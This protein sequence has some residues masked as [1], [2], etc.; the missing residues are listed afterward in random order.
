MI[1]DNVDDKDR[2]VYLQASFPDSYEMLVTAL[3]ANN[4]VPNM[5]TVIK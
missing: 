1:G 5:E 3:E 2:V 4:D